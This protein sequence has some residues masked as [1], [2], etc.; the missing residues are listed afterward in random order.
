MARFLPFLVLLSSARGFFVPKIITRLKPSSAGL[1][2]VAT[3]KAPG[4][5][6]A[7]TS[8]APFPPLKQ[9]KSWP[10]ADSQAVRAS[11]EGHELL[12]VSGQV[13]LVPGTS[14]LIEGGVAAE[15]R[16]ALDNLAAIVEAAAPGLPLGE[17]VM[18]TTVLLADIADFKEVNA[19]YSTYFPGDAKPARAA[20]A[21]GALPLGARVEIEAIARVPCA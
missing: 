6:G 10:R 2:Y 18:K 15:A 9:S 1:S 13:G 21:V 17:A 7:C 3:D 20:Y 11:M 8:R 5:V 19:I 16:Q 12:F 4:A 14:D